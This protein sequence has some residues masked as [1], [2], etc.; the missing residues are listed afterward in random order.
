MK[1]PKKKR[2]I[3]RKLLDSYQGKLCEACQKSHETTGHHIIP[4]GSG[5]DDIVEN[6]LCLCFICHRL[7]HD[8]PLE[9]FLE[10]NPHLKQR[11]IK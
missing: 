4:I 10:K 8:K 3:N 11:L 2:I 1:F 6:L 7:I 5:G 9:D